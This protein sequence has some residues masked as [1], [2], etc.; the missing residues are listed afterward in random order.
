MNIEQIRAH[1]PWKFP[2]REERYVGTGLSWSID[3]LASIDRDAIVTFYEK[4]GSL[5]QLDI[6]HTEDTEHQENV[7]RDWANNE[8]WRQCWRNMA[9]LGPESY[10]LQGSQKLLRQV[11]HDL[12]GGPLTSLVINMSMLLNGRDVDIS[13]IW[14]LARDVRKIARN[15]FPDLDQD[16]YNQDLDEN[17]HSVRLI[18]EKWSR[19]NRGAGV[20][21]YMGFDGN[22][23]TS[24]V[25]FSALDRTLYN[26]M[27]NALRESP[28]KDESVELFMVTQGDTKTE[29]NVRFWVRNPIHPQQQKTLINRFGDDLSDLFLTPFSTTGSGMGMQIVC[30]FV[31]KVYGVSAKRALEMNLA[32]VLLKDGYFNVWFH[33]PTVD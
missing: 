11:I 29:D 20:Q 17:P 26:L 5:M 22:I 28:S 32:G 25:E 16:R 21:V 13:Y 6:W 27:N 9:A 23:A 8:D 3:D 15:C 12:R 18:G 7:V 24:C 2:V 31:G 33:W 19:V 4:I 30:D 14:L 10:I 1:T